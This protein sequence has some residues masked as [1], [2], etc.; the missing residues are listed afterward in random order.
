MISAVGTSS[1]RFKLSHVDS[2]LP[3]DNRGIPTKFIIANANPGR[4]RGLGDVADQKFSL[5]A[6]SVLY[7]LDGT[8]REWVTKR[9]RCVLMFAHHTIASHNEHNKIIKIKG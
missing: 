5:T 7:P 8:W 1:C 3:R 9:Q 2:G 4:D 6:P